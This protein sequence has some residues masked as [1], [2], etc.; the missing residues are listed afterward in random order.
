MELSVA[1]LMD[2]LAS[3]KEIAS[4]L[5]QNNI[6]AHHF[7]SLDEFWVASS[8]QMPDMVFV[9][10]AKMSQGSVQFKSHP[11]VVDV[12]L[13]YVFISFVLFI[14]S[15]LL[16]TRLVICIASEASL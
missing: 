16:S 9:D 15:I 4:A 11:K 14:D 3:A 6:L 2:D 12:S 10:V 7:Q 8:I 13:C 5:R 1:I